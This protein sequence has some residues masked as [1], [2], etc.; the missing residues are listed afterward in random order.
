MKVRILSSAA[1]DLVDGYRFYEKQAPGIGGYFLDALFSDIDSL[2]VNAGIHPIYFERYHRLLSK[3]VSRS[4]FITVWRIRRRWSMRFSIAGEIPRGPGTSC[5][6]AK[7]TSGRAGHTGLN[8]KPCNAVRI[9][10]AELLTSMSNGLAW[11]YQGRALADEVIAWLRERGL[12]LVGVYNLACD[13]EARA[14]P[15]DF[16]FRRVAR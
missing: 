10:R 15:A 11:N 5:V 2:I 4:L 13:R 6:P 3:G 1:R 14:V 8:G 9:Y 16:L 12:R 7:C